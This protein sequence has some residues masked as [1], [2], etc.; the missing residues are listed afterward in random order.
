MFDCQKNC[1][2]RHFKELLE[3]VEDSVRPSKK[4]KW[5]TNQQNFGTLVNTGEKNPI[6][7]QKH[8]NILPGSA[9]TIFT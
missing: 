9:W 3:S 4:I 1:T 6:R 7:N 5:K 8:H 2:E